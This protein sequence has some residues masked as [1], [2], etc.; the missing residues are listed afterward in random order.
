MSNPGIGRDEISV[1]AVLLAAAIATLSVPCESA[2]KNAAHHHKLTVPAQ[3][4]QATMTEST[5]LGAMRYY[6]GPKS[7][8][9]RAVR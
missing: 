5:N 7:P 1:G 8:M 2:A 4:A 6:G 3:N 9:W